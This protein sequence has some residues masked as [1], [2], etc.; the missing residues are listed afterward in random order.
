MIVHVPTESRRNEMSKN[1]NNSGGGISRRKFLTGSAVTATGL[2]LAG[3]QPPAAPPAAPTVAP[4]VPPTVAATVAP[5]VA[6]TAAATPTLAPAT[7]APPVAPTP[8]MTKLKVN[9]K[10]YEVQIEPHWT[11]Q[12]T[13]QFKLGLTGAKTMCD[14]GEC[15]SCTVILDGRPILSCTTLAI[16]CEGK[17]I[18]TVEGIGADP[19]WRPLIQSYMKWDAMQCGYCTPGFVVTAKAFLDKNANPTEEDVK[20]VLAGNICRCGTY[21]RHPKA[22]LEAAQALRGGG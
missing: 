22:V 5:T 20:Q 8:Q 11:L 3:C 13:L 15:G 2:V 10:D 16:E 14:R 17:A 18:E 7:A 12:R 19:K 9:G 1:E 6:P 21:P 4:A